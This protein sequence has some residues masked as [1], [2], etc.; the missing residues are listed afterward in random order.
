MSYKP[1]DGQSAYDLAVA[2]GF[3]GTQ[4]QWLASLKGAKGDQGNTGNQGVQGITGVAGDQGIQG[5]QGLTG[6]QGQTGSTGQTGAQG[7]QGIQGERGIDGTG[8]T[9][10]FKMTGDK[11]VTSTTATSV[12]G[13]GVGSLTL[14]ANFWTV[15]KQIRIKGNGRYTVAASLSQVTIT[16]KIGTTTIASVVTTALSVASTNYGFDFETTITCRTT[17]TTGTLVAMGN[18]NYNAMLSGTTLSRLFDDLNPTGT[19]ATINTTQSAAIDITVAWG[20]VGVGKSL[21]ISS[22]TI[23]SIN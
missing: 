5:I 14:P 18:V 23:E 21:T 15:G 19:T 13:T 1:N 20:G 12:I 7:I 8:V 3:V 17:G 4:A 22:A 6:L 10:L 11:T 2:N 9:P 16:I